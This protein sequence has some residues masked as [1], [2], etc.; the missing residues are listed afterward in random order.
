MIRVGPAGI[1]LAVKGQSY[2]EALKYCRDIGLDALEVQYVRGVKM[3]EDVARELYGL[4]KEFD[5]KLS[6]H[7]PYFINLCGDSTTIKKSQRRIV[8]TCKIGKL[9]EAE[10][11]VV[12]PAYYGK[13]SRE[14]ANKMVIKAI[15]E[16]ADECPIPIGIETMGRQSQ[17][18]PVEDVIKIV[19]ETGQ[20]IVVDWAHIHAR[21]KGCFKT[22]EDFLK[23]L[24]L[25]EKE[26]GSKSLKNLHQH[27]TQVLYSPTGDEKKHLV[28][29]EGDMNFRFLAEAL[30]EV[31]V[32]G[33]IISE[34][35]VLEVDAVKFKQILKEFGLG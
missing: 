19:H 25:I 30:K 35:P 23:I 22:K 7:A 6:C 2:R 31:G 8:E 9:Y 26:L 13:Y 11:A 27:F 24:N 14:E 12:H 5:V 20:R 33:T 32:G 17:V 34:S 21:G 16:I 4:S 1:P 29:E 3:K 28:F 10:L 18:G 15:N